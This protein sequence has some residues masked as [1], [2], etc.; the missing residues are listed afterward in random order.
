[1]GNKVVQ[2]IVIKVNS[3]GSL[4]A[5]AAD[6]SKAGKSVNGL[7]KSENKLK[8]AADGLGRT[9][10][11]TS[12]SFAKQAQGL[13]GLVRVYATVA[14]N[15][16]ALSSAY[17]VLR[18]NADFSNLIA[19]SNKLGESS[20]INFNKVAESLKKATGG[21]LDFRDALRL[22]NLGLAGG[23]NTKQLERLTTVATK[24]AQ[25][26]GRSVSESVNR[27]IQGVVKAEPELL[28]EFGI[29]LRLQVATRKYAAANNL[30]A[31]SLT[32]FQKQQAVILET[33]GQGE[34]KFKNVNVQVNR[35]EELLTS[36]TSVTRGFLS[37]VSGVLAPFAKFIAEDPFLQGAILVGLATKITTLA[38]PAIKEYGT[39]LRKNF[40]ASAKEAEKN[41]KRINKAIN[42]TRKQL[43]EVPGNPIRA[44]SVS[45]T[46]SKA[47]VPIADTFSKSTKLGQALAKGLTGPSLLRAF[48]A[49]FN[50]KV[51]AELAS[52]IQKATAAGSTTAIFRGVEVPVKNL[53]QIDF[54]L[55]SIKANGKD[56]NLL[57]EKQILGME[58]LLLQTKLVAQEAAKTKNSLI[59]SV[60]GAFSNVFATKGIINSFSAINKEST[61]F[62][63]TIGRNNKLIRATGKGLAFATLGATKLSIALGSLSLKIVPIIGFALILKD[64]FFSILRFFNLTS[65]E[66]ANSSNT[67]SAAKEQLDFI[68]NS[69]ADINK[70]YATTADNLKSIEVRAKNLSNILNSVAENA[71]KFA[72]SLITNDQLGPIDKFFKAL[73]KG[74]GF[75]FTNQ[76]KSIK[77]INKSIITLNTLLGKTGNELIFVSKNIPKGKGFDTIKKAIDNGTITS[78]ETLIHVFDTVGLSIE[79]NKAALIVFKNIISDSFKA[80]IVNAN[81]AAVSI[82][83]IGSLV[84]KINTA[85]RK[86]LR[87]DLNKSTLT[88]QLNDLKKLNKEL[89]DT[90]KTGSK[91]DVFDFKNLDKLSTFGGELADILNIKPTSTIKEVQDSLIQYKN[92]IKDIIETTQKLNNENKLLGNTLSDLQNSFK[93]TGD[94]NLLDKIQEA[95]RQKIAND[96][97]ILFAQR[98]LAQSTV[99]TLQNRFNRQGAKILQAG[100]MPGPLHKGELRR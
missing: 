26:T 87:K 10:L 45:N 11:N 21:V 75:D 19:A 65:K 51:G 34:S 82:K 49:T 78:V 23:A 27:I 5:V 24:A 1:M 4:K 14:A 76:T 62:G 17:L 95:K 88:G 100:V 68:N 29:I 6:A 79:K 40:E 37:S 58:K 64:I 91:K 53:K 22:T 44:K 50:G 72:N 80:A 60:K 35:F 8:R 30:A 83:N 33:I 32:T 59:G 3:D 73:K 96:I 66:A 52:V 67:L 15:V 46:V 84:T 90:I 97:N 92:K 16:F 81:S 74:R 56:I 36:I 77:G 55:N 86:N 54:I 31:N 42:K 12:K 98:S 39:S 43:N 48:K 7:T 41:S 94:L 89:K 93:S 13:G 61:K 47:L 71:D 70:Q 63:N 69:V 85:I 38:I 20:G 18:N 99:D 25:A 57:T 2:E 28:D 9:N